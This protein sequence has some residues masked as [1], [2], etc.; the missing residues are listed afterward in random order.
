[1]LR[2]STSRKRVKPQPR[3]CQAR[4]PFEPAGHRRLAVR[5]GRR[6]CRPHPLRAYR[7][8]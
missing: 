8:G 4:D 2:P 1:M 6:T 5:P 7:R 3:R